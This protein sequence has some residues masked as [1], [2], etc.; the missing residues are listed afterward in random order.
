METP[1]KDARQDT[2]KCLPRS[3]TPKKHAKTTSCMG[4]WLGRQ[5]GVNKA[6]SFFKLCQ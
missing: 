3:K 1:N 6:R 4:G 5:Q 2:S